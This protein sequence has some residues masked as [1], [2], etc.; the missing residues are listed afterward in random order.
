[1][2]ASY[3][4]TLLAG[5]ETRQ[6]H[7]NKQ[8]SGVVYLT[9]LGGGVFGNEVEWISN[10]IYRACTRLWDSGLDVRIVVFGE[11]QESRH[12]LSMIERFNA[13]QVVRGKEISTTVFP[14]KKRK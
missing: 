2:D 3:E 5:L 4:A 6:R 8:N 11:S 1:L 14:R 13:A 9:L 12:V 7:D 10:A